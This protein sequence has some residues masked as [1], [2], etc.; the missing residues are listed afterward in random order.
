MGDGALY[1]G[2]QHRFRPDATVLDELGREERGVSAVRICEYENIS[3]LHAPVSAI[4]ANGG[5]A[6]EVGE[7]GTLF[8]G[9]P[10][11]P[12]GALGQL[13]RNGWIETA[14]RRVGLGP[15]TREIAVKWGIAL[16]PPM[17]TLDAA[18]VG[19]PRC[20]AVRARHRH[21]LRGVCRPG[22]RGN[23]D[24]ASVITPDVQTHAPWQFR[25]KRNESGDRDD[26]EH[27]D[28]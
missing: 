21:L 26:R 18:A 16:C 12:Q 19:C 25:D 8:D 10:P 3:A 11:L 7:H 23:T 2:L 4:V 20:G 5:N 1:D 6:I 22:L 28:T 24:G 17:R 27:G 13:L 14:G 15:R 9:L